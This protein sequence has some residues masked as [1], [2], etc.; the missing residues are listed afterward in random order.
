VVVGRRALEIAHALRPT[1]PLY[2]AADE[3][4]LTLYAVT[5][6]RIELASAALDEI[7]QTS[8]GGPLGPYLV[9]QAE[10]FARLRDDLRGWVNTARRLGNDLGL[11]P[12]SRARLGLD[13][14]ATQRILGAELLERYGG[15]A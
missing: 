7:D 15:A 3:P 11:S 2:S 14:A 1:L 8:A 10:K 9:E 13:L 5:L 12:T 4:T 6:A